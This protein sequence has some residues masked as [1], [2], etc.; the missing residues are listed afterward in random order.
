M[1]FFNIL[2][3]VE[4]CYCGMYLTDEHGYKGAKSSPDT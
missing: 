3:I 4:Q 2:S 1:T